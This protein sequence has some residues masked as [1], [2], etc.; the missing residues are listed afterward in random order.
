LEEFEVILETTFYETV[1]WDGFID[2]V[3]LECLLEDLEILNILVFVF[4][5]ELKVST[6][7]EQEMYTL[8]LESDTSTVTH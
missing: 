6:F 7:R 1:Y 5:G 4:G 3:K 8:T 2:V